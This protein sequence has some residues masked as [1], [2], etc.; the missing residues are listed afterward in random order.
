MKVQMLRN[1]SQNYGCNLQEGE[2]G[3]VPGDVG[4]AIVAAGLAVDLTPPPVIEAVPDK[5]VIAAPKPAE[6]AG[7]K[8]S[9]KPTPKTSSK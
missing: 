5:P 6:L 9:K 2:T 4:H 3:D 8:G 1:P 7:D